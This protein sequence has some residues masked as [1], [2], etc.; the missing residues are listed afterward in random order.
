MVIPNLCWVQVYTH[1][2]FNISPN[3]GACKIQGLT[4][5]KAFRACKVWGL[6]AKGDV[7][8]THCKVKGLGLMMGNAG[9][10]FV[11][12]VVERLPLLG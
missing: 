1:V 9:R 11:L 6:A 2:R 12:W 5:F 8:V 3:N 4:N 10:G 7:G